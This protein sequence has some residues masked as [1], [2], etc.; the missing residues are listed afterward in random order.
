MLHKCVQNLS[1]SHIRLL[2]HVED[3]DAR[4]WYMKESSE[5]MW[6]VRTLER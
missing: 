6:S 2:I 5:E 4:L 3:E 1:W